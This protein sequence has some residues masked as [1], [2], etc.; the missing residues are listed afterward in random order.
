MVFQP[1]LSISELDLRVDLLISSFFMK[2]IHV[3]LEFTEVG[4]HIHIVF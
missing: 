2:K 1:R 3:L 4:N